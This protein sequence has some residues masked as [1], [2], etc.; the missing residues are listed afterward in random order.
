MRRI[1]IAG[2]SSAGL[3]AARTLR[4]EGFDGELTI[5]E[6]EAHP[7]YDRTALSKDLVT[8]RA[9]VDDIALLEPERLSSLDIRWHRGQRAVG[10]EMCIRDSP[11]EIA[12]DMIAWFDQ[13]GADGF[14][15]LPTDLPEGL[16]DFVEEVVP[17]LQHR[18][19]FRSEYTSGGLRETLGIP[20]GSLA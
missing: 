5:V 13:H 12:A 10:L 18:G 3:A 19:V 14:N 1:V 9:Q 16:R 4:E 17:R 20:K 8:G 6:P 2:G 15:I 11:D 7:P